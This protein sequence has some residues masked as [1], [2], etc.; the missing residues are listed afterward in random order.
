LLDIT[1]V[2]DRYCL[3]DST[4]TRRNTRAAQP[5]VVTTAHLVAALQS[6][7]LTLQSLDLVSRFAH[8]PAI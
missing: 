5:S 2:I 6:I 7:D 3:Y 1:R 8:Q 4:V